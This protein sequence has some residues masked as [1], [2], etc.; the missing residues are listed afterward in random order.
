MKVW[1][2]AASMKSVQLDNNLEPTYNSNISLQYF[3]EVTASL[4]LCLMSTSKDPIA[5]FDE[6]ECGMTANEVDKARFR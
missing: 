1:V 2:E 4:S 3:L 6:S 5:S